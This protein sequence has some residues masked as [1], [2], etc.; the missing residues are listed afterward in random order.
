[1]PK[2]RLPRQID[3]ARAAG[4]SPAVVSLVVN[5]KTD[6]KIR[7]SSA[8]QQRVREEVMRLGYVPNLAARSLATG[9][10]WLLG[11]F[12]F[13]P[14]FPLQAPNFYFPFLVGIEEAAERLGYNLML[15]TRSSGRG[16]S[17]SLYKD[18]INQLQLADG[19]I[20]LGRHEKRDELLKLLQDGFPFV[21]VGRR[22]VPGGELSYVA[23]DYNSATAEIVRYMAAHGHRRIAY[24]GAASNGEAAEDR[25]AGYRLA[26]EQLG[27]PLDPGLLKRIEVADF[28]S[29]DLQALM[30]QGVTAVVAEN[31]ALTRRA[32]QVAEHSVRIPEELSLAALADPFHGEPLGRDVTAFR[33][34]RREMGA[35]A[36]EL[37]ACSLKAHGSAAPQRD[38]LA[39]AFYAGST[40]ARVREG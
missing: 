7:I 34:P 37:L 32:L 27:W 35:R 23:A 1:M 6:N 5:N 36:V 3:I 29:H 24:L 9:K 12:T 31:D 18:G 20:L 25:E 40:V 14:I 10:N 38:M 21:Y 17:R 28:K 11:V 15:C 19:A 4:V 22:S 8:T 26:H 39:C 30:A 33:I 13:E 2:K 16:G